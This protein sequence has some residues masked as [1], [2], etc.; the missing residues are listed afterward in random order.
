MEFAV[1][2]SGPGI[3]QK[4][5]EKLFKRFAR[6]DPKDK[7]GWGLG[8]VIAK[9]FVQ[10]QGGEIFVQSDPGKGSCFSFTLPVVG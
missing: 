7:S 4:D 3:S 5:Q 1:K 10:A 6:I 9:D 8:L 2:D